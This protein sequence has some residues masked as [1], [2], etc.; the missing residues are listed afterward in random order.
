MNRRAPFLF[1]QRTMKTA[2]PLSQLKLDMKNGGWPWKIDHPN[3]E[4]ALLNGCYTDFVAAERVREFYLDLLRLPKEGGGTKPFELIDWWYSSILAPLFGW[5]RRDGRRRFDKGFITT[6]KKSGKS[7]VLSGL[8]IYMITAD[9]EEEAEAYAAATDRD[10]ASIIYKKTNRMVK[11]SPPLSRV[12]HRVPSQKRIVH[13]ATGSWFEAISSDADSTE[14]KNPHLLITDELHVWK[15]RQFFNALMYGDIIRPQ[16]IF[17]MIT[18]AGSDQDCVGYEE[19]Q[20]AKALLDP[21]DD[22]YS[23]SHFAFIAEARH[24]REWDDPEGW[25]EAGPS[26]ACGAIGN[27]EKLKAKCAEAKQSPRKQREFRRYICNW[28]VDVNDDP[29]LDVD[30]WRAC[31]TELPDH[32]GDATWG[33]MDLSRTRDLTALCLAFV[34]GSFIDLWWRFWCPED[35]VKQYTDEWRV[36]LDDWVRQG[37]VVATPGRVVDYAWIR[38][39]ISGVMLDE[40]GKPSP[41]LWP[42]RLC[43]KHKIKEIGFDNYNASK[44]V[45]ELGEY[46][47]IQMVDIRQGYALLSGPC[48]EIER[49]VLAGTIRHDGNPVMDWMVRNCVVDTDPFGNVKPNKKKSRQKIDGVSAMAMA[50]ARATLGEG[51]SVYEERGLLEV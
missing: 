6:G 29:W 32:T 49:R 12:L 19:Y 38:R 8:P 11:L 45:T 14:G 47:G 28:W 10:Q 39:D 5:K 27:I 43:E 37:L 50:V 42:E 46:D 9:G 1:A 18:T 24:D 16:P 4:R 17:L 33:G 30:A 3:D 25:K 35:S 22:F 2:K 7:T 20:F 44:L 21:N 40:S 51:A 34:D 48:K 13:E 23:E 31:K 41:D 15:N 36:P 26:L